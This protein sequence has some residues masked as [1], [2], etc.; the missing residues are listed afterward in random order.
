MIYGAAI[1]VCLFWKAWF[2]D[3]STKLF[4]EKLFDAGDFHMQEYAYLETTFQNGVENYCLID[5]E[6]RRHIGD[7]FWSVH[8]SKS[9]YEFTDLNVIRQ[10]RL[11]RQMRQSYEMNAIIC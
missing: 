5:Q 10:T 3:V 11:T 7:S 6:C 9:Y 8:L 4:W 2:Y 1:S